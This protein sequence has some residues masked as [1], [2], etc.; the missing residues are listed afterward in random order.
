MARGKALAYFATLLLGMAAAA[1]GQTSCPPVFTGCIEKIS[2]PFKHT[3]EVSREGGSVNGYNSPRCR[4]SPSQ[5]YDGG[6]AVY[7]VRLNPGNEVSFSLVGQ[8]EA[9]LV[10]ALVSTQGEGASCYSS[11]A[12]FIGPGV[13]EIPAAKY[14][15]GIYYLY[16]DSAKDAPRG[17]YDLTVRGVNPTPDLLLKVNAPRGAFAGNSVTYELSLTNRGDGVAR[18]VEIGLTLPQGME[19]GTGLDCLGGRVTF[20]IDEL[21]IGEEKKQTRKVTARICPGIWGPL[22]ATA[23]AKAAQGSPALPVPAT[24]QVTGQSDL[25]IE[26]TPSAP[27]VVAGKQLTYTFTIHNAGPSAATE[28][29]VEDTLDGKETFAGASDWQCSGTAPVRC[30]PLGIPAGGTV[31]RSITVNTHSSALQPLV[32]RATVSANEEEPG[33]KRR[34]DC[35]PNSDSVETRVERETDLTIVKSQT[36]PGEVGAGAEFSYEITVE[37]PKGPSDSSGALVKDCLPAPLIYVEKDGRCEISNREDDGCA[38]T[39]VTCRIG[40]LD[41]GQKSTITIGAKTAPDLEPTTLFNKAELEAREEDPTGADVSNTVETVLKIKADLRLLSKTAERVSEP[42]VVADSVCGGQNI[43]YT[44]KVINNGPSNSPGGEILDILPKGLSFVSSPDGCSADAQ[45]VT[46]PV[47][48]LRPNESSQEPHTAQIVALANG[49]SAEIVNEA[50]VKGR[51]DSTKDWIKS[52]TVNVLPSLELTL[53]AEEFVK[54]QECLVYTVGVTNLGPS[55]ARAVNVRLDLPG[56]PPTD[57]PCNPSYE[58]V[59]ATQLL[60]LEIPERETYTRKV[61]VVAPSSSG[62]VTGT[63]S[64]ATPYACDQTNN[65]IAKATTTVVAETDMDLAL[66]VTASAETVVIGDQLR[67]TIQVG[68]QGP[69]TSPLLPITVEDILPQGANFESVTSAALAPALPECS[70][71]DA[72]RKLSCKLSPVDDA[73][74]D[75]VVA[76]KVVAPTPPGVHAPLENEVEIITDPTA[77]ADPDPTDNKRLIETPLLPGPLLLPFFEVA[78]GSE[79]LTTLFA[80]RNLS[81]GSVNLRPDIYVTSP[82][83]PVT[84]PL[85]LVKLQDHHATATVNLRAVKPELAGTTGYVAIS[86]DPPDAPRPLLG[87]DFVRFDPTR[88]T[89]SGELLVPATEMCREW[90]VRF[91]N[92]KP[93][94]SSTD[95]L[96]FVP[97]NGAKEVIGKVYNEEGRFVQT[98]TF[99]APQEAFKKTMGDLQLLAG[100]GSIE[101]SFPENVVG[102]VTAIHKLGDKDEVA[103]PGFC[104]TLQ[105]VGGRSSLILPFFQVDPNGATTYLAIRNET[106]KELKV[107]IRTFTSAGTSPDNQLPELLLAGHGTHTVDLRRTGISEGYMTVEVL[108]PALSRALSG[109]YILVDASGDL[110][111]SALVDAVSPKQLCQKWDVRFVRD[112]PPG[113]NTSFLFY[114]EGSEIPTGNAYDE[115][116][117]H[118][119]EVS[120]PAPLLRSSLISMSSLVF[121][122]APAFPD[123][124]LGQTGR[125]EWDLGEGNTGHVAMLF[126]SQGSEGGYSV[127][128]PGICLED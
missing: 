72:N 115:S 76:V 19:L 34:R 78:G 90:S 50:S 75:I 116:G 83:P 99:M 41:L 51:E 101:W 6:E 37:N 22:T 123:A 40:P 29:M 105:D 53:S 54:V 12:D 25:S 59:E 120:V 70:G 126:T 3:G 49:D 113:S 62:N 5:E 33:C 80:V 13:E 63:A 28:V 55:T 118:L 81:S 58:C 26:I 98:I 69:A 119:G 64:F 38:G 96:F 39:L 117:K 9:D 15:P 11:S 97:G 47:P 111:G 17:R 86:T 4:I 42:G 23:D 20:R 24:I 84:I 18:N 2:E 95:I 67:Y 91:L 109:D 45:T 121:T 21:E 10:L 43:L 1:S 66:S 87:G 56:S 107:Q 108:E 30:G 46:C 73:Y 106:D 14:P 110:A 57:P 94:G 122:P 77:P 79:E 48:P 65:K 31:T 102:N 128:I 8:G 88:R 16:I 125:I 36:P 27:S 124:K 103:V 7:E 85:P 127:L 100:S 35:G 89:A 61:C 71:P 32:N 104:R 68:N 44:M 114:L 112:V 93:I 74:P 92:G 52:D 60:D 82:E